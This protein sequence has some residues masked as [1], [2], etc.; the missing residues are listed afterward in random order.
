MR[1][2]GKV[3]AVVLVTAAVFA[4][5]VGVRS[6]PDVQQKPLLVRDIPSGTAGN[7]S[8][9][10]RLEPLTVIHQKACPAQ[11][12][13]GICVCEAGNNDIPR[14]RVGLDQRLSQTRVGE[15]VCLANEDYRRS[16]RAHSCG[17]P[18]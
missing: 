4:V 2:L 6:I 1:S 13:L 11:S 16:C 3:T 5:G 15:A 14:L 7:L 9:G 17:S 18:R 10:Q 8:C 12:A